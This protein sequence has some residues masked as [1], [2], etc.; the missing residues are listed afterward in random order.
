MTVRFEPPDGLDGDEVHAA[1]NV[2]DR[3]ATERIRDVRSMK[4]SSRSVFRAK[5]GPAA[6]DM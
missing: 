5:Y 6:A 1:N 2:V 3:A 4:T